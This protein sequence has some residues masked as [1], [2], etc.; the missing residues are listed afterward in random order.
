MAVTSNIKY[1]ENCSAL[2]NFGK[3][4]EVDAS[5]AVVVKNLGDFIIKLAPVMEQ[6][7]I[8]VFI[9]MVGSDGTITEVRQ[10]VN[11]AG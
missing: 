2:I 4:T 5:G 10:E 6:Q 9:S 1:P 3:I 7:R 11:L 8:I